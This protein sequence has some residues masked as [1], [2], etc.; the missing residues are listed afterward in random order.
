MPAWAA[1][2][3]AVWSKPG[4]WVSM[5][6]AREMDRRA[7]AEGTVWRAVWAGDAAQA[8]TAAQRG[9]GPAAP[10]RAAALHL[11]TTPCASA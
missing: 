1:P 3:E 9:L 2:L 7:A 6:L 11:D 8:P 10:L 5:S 4:V